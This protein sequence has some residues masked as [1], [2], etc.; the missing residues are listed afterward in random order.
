MSN[1]TGKPPAAEKPAR[2]PV[3]AKAEAIAAAWAEAREVY[4]VYSYLAIQFHFGVPP[5]LESALSVACP[6]SD[7]FTKVTGWLDKM[8]SQIRTN[9]LRQLLHSMR[10]IR[11]ECL[12]ALILR[13]LRRPEKTPTDR[14]NVDLLLATYFALC[15]PEDLY[16]CEI[17]LPDVAQ[18]L[19]GVLE[20]A[21]ATELE[22][23]EPL[24]QVLDVMKRCQGLRQVFQTKLLE[25]GRE[26]KD[27]AGFMF[28]DP[29]A[30]VAFTRFNFLARRT[31][32]RLLHADLR[33]I[34]EGLAELERRGIFAVDCRAAGLGMQEGTAHLREI[35]LS[36]RQ[37]I[38]ADYA[39]GSANR[40]FEQLLAIRAAV[41]RAQGIAPQEVELPKFKLPTAQKP[42]AAVPSIPASPAKIANVPER[43]VPAKPAEPKKPA[44]SAIPK[45]SAPVLVKTQTV[46]SAPA[47]A[48]PTQGQAPTAAP[49]MPTVSASRGTEPIAVP[50]PPNGAERNQIAPTA[51]QSGASKRQLPSQEL[52]N[53]LE[54]IWEQLI[55]APPVRGRSMSTVALGNAKILL[56]AW[57]VN[58]FVSDGGQLSEDLRRAVAARALVALAREEQKSSGDRR[59][60]DDAIA[61]GREEMKYL[62][63]RVDQAQ[64]TKDTEAAVNLGIS[65]RRLLSALEEAPA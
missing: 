47:K 30:L 8:D 9:Q 41:E 7:V 4:P 64:R 46:P 15:A 34:R 26:L 23:C 3:M 32:F 39:D 58:A 25:K 11:P 21:D 35:S 59:K 13:L 49:K 60:L 63:G 6:A 16:S 2:G 40:T 65:A 52:D 18:V 12:R 14:D 17:T 19:H 61:L 50:K 57:E 51:V 5:V 37:P 31:F 38:S 1:L 44:V 33:A 54:N 10:E 45:P 29:A 43:A 56:S 27:A 55:E 53:C 36:W 22:W 20:D 48:M 62:Q 28:Y 42:Q 24:N